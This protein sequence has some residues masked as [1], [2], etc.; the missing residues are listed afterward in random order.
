MSDFEE[1]AARR[2]RTWTGGVSKTFSEHEA[3]GLVFWAE[4]PPAAR[5]QAMW[6]AIIEAWIVQGKNGPPP[7]LQGSLVGVGRHER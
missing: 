5:L 6:D 7:R 4:A 1:R 3:R 2:R